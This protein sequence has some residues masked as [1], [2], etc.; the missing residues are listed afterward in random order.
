MD[1]VCYGLCYPEEFV[2]PV[3]CDTCTVRCEGY[4][5]GWIMIAESKRSSNS[6]ILDDL[7]NVVKVYMF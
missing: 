3:L 4:L 7:T 1:F 2:K 5:F 6:S